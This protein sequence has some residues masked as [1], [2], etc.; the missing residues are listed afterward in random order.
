MLY[1]TPLLIDESDKVSKQIESGLI[2]KQCVVTMVL[3]SRE[4]RVPPLNI[5]RPYSGWRYTFCGST[6]CQNDHDARS[7]CQEVV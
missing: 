3:S 6:N 2:I 5:S 4:Y 1:C 7:Y